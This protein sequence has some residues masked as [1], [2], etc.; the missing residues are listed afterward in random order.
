MASTRT[1]RVVVLYVHPLLGEGVAAYLRQA[2][3]AEVLTAAVDNRAA[4]ALAVRQ[5]P[6]VVVFEDSPALGAA[7]LARLA[8][9]AT[10]IDISSATASG[11]RIP[12]QASA[13]RIETIVD[14]I[15]HDT[16]AHAS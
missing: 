13:P 8:P 7:E 9:S 10:V 6:D 15:T 11:A 16:T 1:T 12:E 3:G 14:A 2:T 5:A 4:V